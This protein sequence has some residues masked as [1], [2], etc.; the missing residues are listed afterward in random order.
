MVSCKAAELLYRVV[1]LRFFRGYLIKVHMEGCA[2]CEARLASRGEAGALFVDP[3]SAGMTDVLRRRV[4]AAIPAPGEDAGP[5]GKPVRH[6]LAWN[7]AA[8]AAV[9]AVTIAAALW[10]LTAIT[11][12]PPGDGRTLGAARFEVGHVKVGGEPA[13]SVVYRPADSDMIIVWAEKQL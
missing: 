6:A 10:L 12:G 8:G 4:V 5:P 13:R 1:P 7:W 2:R 9:A 3:D 11:P